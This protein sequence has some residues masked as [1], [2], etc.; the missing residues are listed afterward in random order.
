MSTYEVPNPNP[1]TSARESAEDVER[2]GRAALM[3][4]PAAGAA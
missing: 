2:I 3:F 1:P 4:A